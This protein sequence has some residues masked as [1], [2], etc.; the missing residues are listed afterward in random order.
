MLED[1]KEKVRQ[2]ESETASATSNSC[3]RKKLED[4][5][6]MTKVIANSF[7]S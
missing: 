3:R 5:S 7:V 1:R 6:W 4:R 2:G